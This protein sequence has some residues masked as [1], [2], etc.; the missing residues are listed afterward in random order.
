MVFAFYDDS[1]FR[2]TVD[3]DQAR[4]EGL[5]DADMIDAIST[6]YGSMARP[7]ATRRPP[8]AS[9]YDDPGTLLAQ[10]GGAA[11]SVRL[12]RLTSYTTR[13]R[14]VVT[15]EPTAA[16]ARSAAARALVL[17]DREAPQREA[18]REKKEDDDRRAAEEKARSTNKPTFRP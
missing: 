3:Y 6:V 16:L 18:A 7:S 14:M 15:A 10:W 13:F 12:Y 5:S 1:L 8:P 2:I 17:D 9:V 4:T 11:N